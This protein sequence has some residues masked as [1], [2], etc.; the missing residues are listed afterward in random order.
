MAGSDALSCSCCSRRKFL[1]AALVAL[2]P[3]LAVWADAI[4]VVRK[5]ETLSGLARKY[6]VPL[7]EL[8]AANDLTTTA[9]IKIGERLKIPVR[10]KHPQLDRELARQLD[11]TRVKPGRWKHIV[12]H[13]T[14]EPVGTFQAIDR[15]HREELH[16]ENGIAY[17]FLIGNGK[18]MKEGEIKAS[19]RWTGQLQ[20]GHVRSEELN[21]ISL[22]ICLVGNFE[23]Q[24]PSQRQLEALA[25]LINYLLKRCRLTRAAVKTHKQI[26][27]VS[28]LCPGRKFPVRELMGMVA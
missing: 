23:K 4:H 26:N 22:G 9:K 27:P 21:Q 14:A 25:G 1:G 20:G 17:H 15:Y 12:V 2:F 18:G 24:V 10:H 5:G 8:A 11:K 3:T 13:H 6:E 16:M 7:A 28:T 19:R